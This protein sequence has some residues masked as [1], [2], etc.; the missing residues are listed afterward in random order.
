MHY[1]MIAQ[2]LQSLQRHV[3]GPPIMLIN[4]LLLFAAAAGL[5]SLPWIEDD[6]A[7]A[8]AEAKARHVPLM[9]EVWAPW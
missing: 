6:Y 7:K 2:V 1:G 3:V 9:V 5:S 8:L 4:T